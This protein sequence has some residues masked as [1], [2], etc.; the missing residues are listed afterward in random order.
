MA[1]RLIQRCAE[2]QPRDHWRLV[3]KGLR[4][5][6]VLLR[7]RRVSARP[8]G[9]YDV[10]YVGMASGT[11]GIRARLQLHVRSRRKA[12]VFTHFSLYAVWPNISDAEVGEL[13]GLFRHIYR[14]DPRANVLNKSKG[15]GP[16]Y[17]VRQNNLR[18]WQ[19]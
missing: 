13:E 15:F 1:L 14:K 6:Y 10:V 19:L 2:W 5:I 12:A 8:K 18:K 16:V 4:G 7:Q 9:T 11:A 17:R 3:P